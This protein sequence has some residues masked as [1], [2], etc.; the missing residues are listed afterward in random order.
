MES[1][2]AVGTTER[3]A[4]LFA[5]K[6]G[7]EPG[8]DF[9]FAHCPERVL[10]GQIVREMDTNH[11]LAGGITPE[12]TELT[13]EFLKTVFNPEL[14]NPTNS[15]VSE[16]AKLAENAFR[17][18]NIA[19]ANEL[20]KICTTFSID[21]SEVIR[22]ANL[23]P[24]VDILNPGLGVGGYCLPKDGWILV[25]S[26]RDLAGGADLIPTARAVNDSMPKH[27]LQRIL[28]AIID[29]DLSSPRVALLGLSFKPNVSDMRNS[30]TID[31][32]HLLKK[33]N[34]DTVV[35]DPL[36]ETDVESER[37]LSID[38]VV[39]NCDILVLCVNH[40]IIMDEL[41]GVDLSEKVFVDP[42]N[43]MRKLRNKARHYVG[44]S[45]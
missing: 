21:V 29:S 23:H 38:E 10:P 5:E 22:L 41:T 8:K 4:E 40:K 7:L 30:P 2:V 9:W 44:L 14:I 6:T 19:Y 11:R 31:L 26:A 1:T 3:L 45:S 13:V 20:A 24:R 12:S 35:Y 36:V 39:Q 42:G 43:N 34:V 16:T 25:Q 15:K 18:T 27:T 37:A 28:S 33:A 17:D 32:L